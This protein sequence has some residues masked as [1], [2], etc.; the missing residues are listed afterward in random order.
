MEDERGPN[1][2]SSTDCIIY[3]DMNKK[4][5]RPQSL[6]NCAALNYGLSGYGNEDK[7]IIWIITPL[8]SIINIFFSQKMDNSI[9]IMFLPNLQ[10]VFPFLLL[11]MF[12]NTAKYISFKEKI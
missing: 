7:C 10:L 5:S 11:Q 6:P 3:T 2:L 9:K 8:F 4:F 12:K 1:I